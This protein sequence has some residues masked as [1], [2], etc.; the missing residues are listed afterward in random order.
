[1]IRQQ[2]AHRRI[3]Q[4]EWVGRVAS[5]AVSDVGATGLEPVKDSARNTRVSLFSGAE[6]GAY[7][8]D[9]DLEV[10]VSA[11]GKLPSALKAGMVAMVRTA[12][13]AQ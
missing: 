4:V 5:E 7:L 13:G 12:D 2:G 8:N 10:V 1:L 9:A 3:D 11:W 6:C